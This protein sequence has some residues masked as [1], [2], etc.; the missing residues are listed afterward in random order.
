LHELTVAGAGQL[1]RWI[2]DPAAEDDVWEQREMAEIVRATLACISADYAAILT[3]KY[4]DDC[5]LEEITTQ[6]GGTV[7]ATKSKL[8]R[9]RREF[10]AKF[11][12]ITRDP[13]PAFDEA[14]TE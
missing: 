1:R 3:S 14:K 9:A 12:R 7:D 5:S 13:N 8:A 11:E 10:R 6:I 2:D 4:L